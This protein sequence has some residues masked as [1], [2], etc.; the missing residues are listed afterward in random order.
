MPQPPGT[1]PPSS[2]P[3]AH[4]REAQLVAAPRAGDEEGFRML[5]TTWHATL[6]RVPRGPWRT[7]PGAEGVVQETW[8]APIAGLDRFEARAGL[9]TWLFHTPPNRA[10]TRGVREAR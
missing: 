10:R 1:A 9:N 4:A 7:D 8:L 3:P 6:K 2:R 5:V